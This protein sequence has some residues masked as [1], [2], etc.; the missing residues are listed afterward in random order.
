VIQLGARHFIVKP[1]SAPVVQAK[2]RQIQAEI[3][4]EAALR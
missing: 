3:A 2:L 4:A 1:A